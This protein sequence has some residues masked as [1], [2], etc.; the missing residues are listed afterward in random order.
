M[1]KRM[2]CMLLAIVVLVGLLPVTAFAAAATNI[3]VSNPVYYDSGALKSI[4]TSFGW[5]GGL[6]SGRLVLT[7]KYLRSEGSNGYVYGD[8]SDQ[9]YYAENFNFQSFND[10]LA[11]DQANGDL[12]II[13]YTEQKSISYS[14]NSMTF[15]FTE[16]NIPLGIDG[17]YY[18]YFW[19]IWCGEYY[20]DNL[21]MAIEVKNGGVSYT[22]ADSSKGRNALSGTSNQVTSSNTYNVT[23]TAAENMTKTDDSGAVIQSNLNSAMTPVVFTANDGYTFPE[24]YAVATINGI[25]V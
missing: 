25:M 14:N 21:I 20:P 18:V 1:K 11:H 5:S 19:T 12:G 6:P 16:N 9:G 7:T 24:D 4:T 13:T 17:T 2:I 23:V 10:V 3:E 15:S 8:F 22:V